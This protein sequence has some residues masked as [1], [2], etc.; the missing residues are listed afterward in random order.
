MFDFNKGSKKISF[1]VK[2]GRQVLTEIFT[3]LCFNITAPLFKTIFTE[4]VY[5]SILWILDNLISQG[6]IKEISLLF[7][8]IYKPVIG[9][10][11][12][13]S[14][15]FLQWSNPWIKSLWK[16]ILNGPW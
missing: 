15:G 6:L 11:S 10:L 3:L 16:K 12:T 5:E 8:L 1:W 7:K 9:K 14:N 4:L 2:K 13:R